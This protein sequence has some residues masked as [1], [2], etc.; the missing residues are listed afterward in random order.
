[1]TASK[2]AEPPKPSTAAAGNPASQPAQSGA[3]GQSAPAAA[4][5]D[6]AATPQPA[7]AKSAPPAPPAPP[8]SAGASGETPSAADT[9]NAI[10]AMAAEL[11]TAKKEAADNYDRCLRALADNE[12]FRRRALR[13]KDEIRLYAAGRV[14][15]D[16]FPVIE[17]LTLGINAAKAPGA[18]A[19]SIVN[20]MSMVL[21][22]LKTALAGHGLKEIH[23][24]GE[25]FD[26][27]LHQALATQP[28]ADVPEGGIL[29]VFRTGYALNGRVLRPASVIVSSG[30][31]TDKA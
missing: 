29:Q 14:L 21:D 8:A 27:N 6:G 26:P 18:D 30:P 24:E 4:P 12:N 11:A 2:N 28:S 3:G 16:L 22:Q 19:A 7:A 9:Q 13:E 10:L 17:A 31:K 5:A 20:G 15:E 23:P 1:M 25:K